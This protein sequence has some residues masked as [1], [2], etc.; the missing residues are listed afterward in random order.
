MM[1]IVLAWLAHPWTPPH[2]APLESRPLDAR[3]TSLPSGV[4]DVQWVVDRGWVG[5]LTA[6]SCL[7]M[8]PMAPALLRPLNVSTPVLPLV[9]ADRC[10][11]KPSYPYLSGAHLSSRDDPSLI[12]V[13]FSDAAVDRGC[14]AR[15]PS[16]ATLSSTSY[17]ALTCIFLRGVATGRTTCRPSNDKHRTRRRMRVVR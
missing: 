9:R 3:S 15:V 17:T 12:F 16:R 5:F 2:R 4:F 7:V 1:A 6:W 13:Q 14:V 11:P 10:H 8:E